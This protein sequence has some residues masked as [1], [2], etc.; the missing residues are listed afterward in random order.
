[1]MKIDDIKQN[2]L[3]EFRL[4]KQ[5]IDV[6]EKKLTESTLKDTDLYDLKQFYNEVFDIRVDIEGLI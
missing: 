5:Y 1:M 6:I 3:N 2:I 4:A